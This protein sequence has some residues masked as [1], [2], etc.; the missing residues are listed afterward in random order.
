[1]RN[2]K[3]TE[4]EFC[5]RAISLTDHTVDQPLRAR[6]PNARRAE[7]VESPARPRH[8]F[9][10]CRRAGKKR[11]LFRGKVTSPT[12]P[13]SSR[14]AS[15]NTRRATHAT[16]RQR[17]PLENP[18]RASLRTPLGAGAFRSVRGRGSGTESRRFG[19]R[20]REHP[21]HLH[22]RHARVLRPRV[23]AGLPRR[24]APTHPPRGGRAP[25][26]PRER[27]ARYDETHARPRRARRRASGMRFSRATG[28]SLFF[29]VR[30]TA[31]PPSP[32]PTEE[33]EQVYAQLATLKDHLSTRYA[34]RRP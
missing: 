20:G 25:Q 5:V 26:L 15:G 2:E 1:M 16:T 28:T 18:P 8:V 9:P 12:R 10:R 22:F 23:G 24:E 27:I 29:R 11:A 32:T 31:T 3:E 13:A 34:L 4:S 30:L 33:E 14:R 21:T 7:N 6:K 17:R 19:V